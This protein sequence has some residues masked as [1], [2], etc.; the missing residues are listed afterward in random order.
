MERSYVKP[1]FKKDDPTDC[2]KYRPISLLRT[3][4]N[5]VEKIVHKHVY[6]FFS[7]N[8]VI[9][10]LKSGFVPSDSTANQLVDIYNT[11]S[12]ALND[13]LEVKAVFL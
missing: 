7:A 6:N 12:K 13:G 3:L 1:V 5:V 10:S 8:N 2:K 4:G 9:T 11:F